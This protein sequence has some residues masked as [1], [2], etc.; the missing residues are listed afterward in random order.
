SLAVGPTVDALSDSAL[1]I[2]QRDGRQHT[3]H[4]GEAGVR[5]LWLQALRVRLW[6]KGSDEPLSH[7]LLAQWVGAREP[8]LIGHVDVDGVPTAAH[9]DAFTIRWGNTASQRLCLC[10][11]S[12]CEPR[13]PDSFGV[14][15]R[16]RGAE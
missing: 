1:R 11:E 13:S 9:L 8:L 3:L 12:R 15:E 4:F 16:E 14:R 7:D 2:V 5:D 6:L 10:H